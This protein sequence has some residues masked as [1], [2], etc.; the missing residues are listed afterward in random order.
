[1]GATQTMHATCVAWDGQ[2]VLITGKSGAGK[3][4]IGL[5]LM[6]MGCDLVADDQVQLVEHD[7]TVI[8]QSPPNIAGL[9]E[10]RGIG[11]LNAA[12]VP[13]ATLR[14]VVDLG[15]TETMRLPQR[16]VI[17]L[18]GCDLP[19]IHHNEGPQFAAAILQTLKAGWSER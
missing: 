8:V 6:G 11:I 12:H 13:R 10:A 18:L 4:A 9:I 14:L 3:S 16:H 1:M 7:G 5:M 19:L 15:Q 2:A 17:T